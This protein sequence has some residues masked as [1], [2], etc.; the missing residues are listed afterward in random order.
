MGICKSCFR[1]RKKDLGADESQAR[2]IRI[3]L[4]GPPGC[5]KGTQAPRIHDKYGVVHLATGDM[6]RSAVASGTPT[7]LQAKTFMDAG[8]LVPDELVIELIREAIVS[9]TGIH[10]FV[11]DGFPRTINQAQKV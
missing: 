7:G 3:V 2:P 10:G 5:G 4:L 6:L 8:K 1:F 9:D 11:L